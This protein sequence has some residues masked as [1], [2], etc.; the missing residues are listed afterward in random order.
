[1]FVAR[2]VVDRGDAGKAYGAHTAA[3]RAATATG[4]LSSRAA[5]FRRV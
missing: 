5:L 2:I 1:M 3:S 4:A